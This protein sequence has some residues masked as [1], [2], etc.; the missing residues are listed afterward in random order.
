MVKSLLRALVALFPATLEAII[1][2]TDCEMDFVW[3]DSGSRKVYNGV[4]FNEVRAVDDIV[5]MAWLFV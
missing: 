1:V 2:D 5:A 3:L 4:D